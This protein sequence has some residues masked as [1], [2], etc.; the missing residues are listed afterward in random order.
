ML[1]AVLA[2]ALLALTVTTLLASSRTV[3]PARDRPA[4]PSTRAGRAGDA[5]DPRDVS[6][7]L[8][9]GLAAM[10]TGALNAQAA[11]SPARSGP[12]S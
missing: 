9:V 8:L 4:S 2:L 11:F 12:R 5:A 3:D 6:Y 7:L 10:A 1:R